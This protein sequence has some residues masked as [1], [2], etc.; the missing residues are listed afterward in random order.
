MSEFNFLEQA[1]LKL[2]ACDCGNINI[3]YKSVTLHFAREEFYHFASAMTKFM[4]QMGMKPSVHSHGLENP[5][6]LRNGFLEADRDFF[7]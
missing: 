3:T 5:T 6:F 2:S 7:D 1:P 4:C